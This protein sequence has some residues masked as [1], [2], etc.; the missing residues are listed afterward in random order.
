MKIKFVVDFDGPLTEADT[1]LIG[2]LLKLLKRHGYT[3]VEVPHGVTVVA[4]EGDHSA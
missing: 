4:K 1:A 2:D 3:N